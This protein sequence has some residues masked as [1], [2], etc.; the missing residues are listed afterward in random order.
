M[1]LNK[2]A[3]FENN[4]HSEKVLEPHLRFLTYTTTC[5]SVNLSLPQLL[6]WNGNKI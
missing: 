3:V 6:E 1:T 2:M 5:Q 4:K